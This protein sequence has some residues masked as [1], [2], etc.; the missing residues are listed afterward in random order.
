M[1]RGTSDPLGILTHQRRL[2]NDGKRSPSST[3]GEVELS[4]FNN[5]FGIRAYTSVNDDLKSI[6]TMDVG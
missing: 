6:P 5:I 2:G 4:H 1:S 3:F